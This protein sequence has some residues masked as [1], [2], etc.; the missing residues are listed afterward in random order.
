M[1]HKKKKALKVKLYVTAQPGHDTGWDCD[2]TALSRAGRGTS[3]A[4]NLC[5]PCF[6]NKPCSFYL[7]RWIKTWQITFLTLRLCFLGSSVLF[8]QLLKATAVFVLPIFFKLARRAFS[9][10]PNWW[11]AFQGKRYGGV[12]LVFKASANII[13][14]PSLCI[15]CT[16]KQNNWIQKKMCSEV[17]AFF[18]AF[19][20][21][22][23]IQ[24][25]ANHK[26]IVLATLFHL[27][28]FSVILTCLLRYWNSEFF[29]SF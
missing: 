16:H 22:S 7:A 28:F 13:F 20:S 10:L 9:S 21:E 6:D 11:N 14:F 8:S 12:I 19:I 18:A 25:L 2:Q 29:P 27:L 3:S 17:R 4:S 15:F 1:T 26:L 23:A 5:I 24:L